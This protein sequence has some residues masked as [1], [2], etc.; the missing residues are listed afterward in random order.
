MVCANYQEEQRIIRQQRQK[1]LEDV[2]IKETPSKQIDEDTNK[3]G[4]GTVVGGI[5]LASMAIAGTIFGI[6]SKK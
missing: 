5:L 6:K 1:K 2:P 3:V 4:V